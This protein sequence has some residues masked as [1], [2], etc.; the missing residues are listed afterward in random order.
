MSEVKARNDGMRPPSTP[1]A[2]ELSHHPN[3]SSISMLTSHFQPLIAHGNTL[4][5]NRS[6]AVSP[7]GEV[8]AA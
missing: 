4:S 2:S 8:N 3:S 7:A 1:A 6:P 5:P